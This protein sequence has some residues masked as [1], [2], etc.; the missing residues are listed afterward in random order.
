MNELTKTLLFVA[1]AVAAVA[2]AWVAAPSVIEPELFSDEGEIFFADFESPDQVESLEVTSFDASTAIPSTFKVAQVDGQW[3]I[4][5][6]SDY[7]AD[8]IERMSKSASLFIGL[9]KGNV[10]SDLAGDH[11]RFGVLEP[12]ATDPGVPLTGRGTRVTFQGKGSQEIGSLIIGKELDGGSGYF[13]RQPGKNRVY[14]VDLSEIPNTRFGDWIQSDLLKVNSLNVTRLVVNNSSVETNG[15]EAYLKKAE[16]LK[17]EK[18]GSGWKLEQLDEGKETNDDRVLDIVGELDRIQIV[19]V[20]RKPEGLNARLEVAKNFELE[21]FMRSLARRGFYYN[22]KGN[23]II[24]DEG[25]LKAIT[26]SGITYTLRF[27]DVIWGSASEVSADSEDE[28]TGGE[29]PKEGQQANRYLMVSVELDEAILEKPAKQALADEELEKRKAARAD[30][31]RIVTAVKMFQSRNEGALPETLTALK[32]GDE[33]H[34]EGSLQ[35]PWGSDYALHDYAFQPGEE[36]KFVVASLGADKA[37]GGERENGDIYSDDLEAE[38]LWTSLA[39][40]W[41][42]YEAELA[43]ARKKVKELE[44]RFGPWYYVI[45]AASYK[46]LKATKADLQKDPEPTPEPPKK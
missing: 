45:D 2:L 31:E 44:E 46:K 15:F 43:D 25:E 23:E 32:G 1:G 19:G 37:E 6:H 39:S 42:K 11:E 27:G 22:P 12:D 29:A 21:A 26:K 40:D 3:V 9:K 5:S 10:R 38:D 17:L 33:P 41:T 8:A 14:V 24:S 20:R 28:A 18:M 30:I 16:L 35:D 34:L 13:V 4:P 7:P 36:G